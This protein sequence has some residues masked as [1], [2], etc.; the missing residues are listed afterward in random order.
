MDV[1]INLD[2]KVTSLKY[3]DITNPNNTLGIISAPKKE[4]KKTPEINN[5]LVRIVVI[6]PVIKQ[7]IINFL[8]KL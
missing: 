3:L 8:S 7:V 1:K 5:P 2:L 4:N 6:I